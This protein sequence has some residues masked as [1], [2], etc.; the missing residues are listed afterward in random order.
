[1]TKGAVRAFVVIPI[2]W[3]GVSGGDVHVCVQ[4]NT[5]RVDA[6]QEARHMTHVARDEGIRQQA[7]KANIRW[8]LVVVLE[9]GGCVGAKEGAHRD[10]NLKGNE[11]C[12]YCFLQC[13]GIYLNATVQTFWYPC[14]RFIHDTANDKGNAVELTR[15]K[16]FQRIRRKTPLQLRGNERQPR[17]EI[18]VAI[19]QKM[20]VAD[21]LHF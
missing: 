8:V 14:V 15:T 7:A 20:H 2:C 19:L 5:C 3:I 4:P 9:N 13:V 18:I 6:G 11:N 10:L 21:K 12:V 16:C 17:Q 1:M